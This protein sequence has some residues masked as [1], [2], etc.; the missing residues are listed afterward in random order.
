MTNKIKANQL[1]ETYVSGVLGDAPAEIPQLGTAGAYGAIAASIEKLGATDSTQIDADIAGIV[2]EYMINGTVSTSPVSLTNNVVANIGQITLTPGD[3]DIQG[4]VGF[5][6]NDTTSVTVVIGAVSLVSA[7]FPGN[8]VRSF[9]STAGEI[10][11]QENKPAAAL[12]I[13]ARYAINIPTY[14]VR[15]T[16]STTLYLVAFSSFTISTV[17][18]FGSI[19]ARRV[20]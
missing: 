1:A 7:G 16:A 19:W 15:V 5:E 11:I 13:G 18:A 12:G 3:W 10:S 6:V 2:G 4:A 20:R 14:R 17:N 8:A 9:P